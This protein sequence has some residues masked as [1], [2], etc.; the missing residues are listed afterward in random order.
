MEKR[1]IIPVFFLVIVV[2]LVVGLLNLAPASELVERRRLAVKPELDFHLPFTFPAKYTEYYGDHFPFRGQ[3][4]FLHNLINLKIFGLSGIN[5]VVVGK[6]GW[7]FLHQLGNK[8]STV[9]YFRSAKLFTRE[10]LEDWKRILEERYRWLSRRGIHYLF[11]IAP[12]KSTVYPEKM[13][14]NIRKVRNYSR[15]DQLAA[16]LKTYSKVPVLDVR[17]A[18]R[19]AKEKYPVYMKT[20]THWNEYGAYIA[21]REVM[22][23][24]SRWYK[25]AEPVPLP[26]SGFNIG[27]KDWSGGD[28]AEMLSL[29]RDV[30]REDI[31]RLQAKP[32]LETRYD[33][34]SLGHITPF[35]RKGYTE[36]HTAKLP[37]IVMVHDSFYKKLKPYISAS[38]SRVLYI[39]DWGMN[40]YPGLVEREKPKIVIDEM[41]ER[42]LLS[43]PP[44]NPKTLEINQDF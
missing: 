19:R 28:L 38:F 15:M 5:K 13:P 4:I 36:C 41:A 26:L 22:K 7:L 34:G 2:P 24:V 37:G 1:I 42:F 27:L 8:P 31:V 23:T 18:L 3:F 25:E 40:F 30:L 14:G 16:Y 33:G 35:V 17:R 9:D 11:L 12:N 44:R 39:W 32:P 29:H 6:D 10:E 43:P 20:D 21:Y